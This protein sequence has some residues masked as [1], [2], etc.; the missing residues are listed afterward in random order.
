MRLNPETYTRDLWNLAEEARLGR[1]F[2]PCWKG[3]CK[4]ESVQATKLC[5]ASNEDKFRAFIKFDWPWQEVYSLS[6][7]TFLP[8]EAVFLPS[9]KLPSSSGL[10]MIKTA[11]QYFAE[12]LTCYLGGDGYEDAV[13]VLCCKMTDQSLQVVPVSF[14]FHTINYHISCVLRNYVTGTAPLDWSCPIHTMVGPEAFLRELKYGLNRTND[15]LP[16]AGYRN[17]MEINHFLS[18]VHPLIL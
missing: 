6:L 16:R 8:V 10:R 18:V 9:S 17:D 15:I 1:P 5:H 7:A 2:K 3:L 4:F 12:A 11:L 13:N 14:V